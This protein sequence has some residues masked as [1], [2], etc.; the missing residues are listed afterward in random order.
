[1]TGVSVFFPSRTSEASG[2]PIF[3]RAVSWLMI[4][5]INLWLHTKV[6]PYIHWNLRMI[7]NAL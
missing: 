1:V 7:L 3:V 6:I 4:Y 5:A 2:T